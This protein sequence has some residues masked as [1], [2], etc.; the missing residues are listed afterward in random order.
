MLPEVLKHLKLTKIDEFNPAKLFEKIEN[1]NENKYLA[2][3]NKIELILKEF[4]KFEDKIGFP[5]QN[6]INDW[7]PIVYYVDRKTGK[8]DEA[9][10]EVNSI[11]ELIEFMD[12]DRMISDDIQILKY[13]YEVYEQ[14][15]NNDIYSIVVRA[16]SLSNDYE[17][18]LMFVKDF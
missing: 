16:I 17:Y 10:I 4:G 7:I 14:K 15:N 5:I 11:T 2:T 12:E 18:W 8:F 13:K 9:D 3:L 1:K 6:G